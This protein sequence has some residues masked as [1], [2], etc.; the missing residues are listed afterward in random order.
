MRLPVVAVFIILL[1][2]LPAAQSLEK[3]WA[4]TGATLI[5]GTGAAP[6]TDAVIVGRGERLVCVGRAAHCQLP[7]G[8]AIVD[9]TGKWIIPGL[10]DTHIHPG[11][12]NGEG[13]TRAQALRLAFG[14]TTTRDAGT[15][16]VFL[17]NLARRDTARMPTAVEPRLIVSAVVSQEHMEHFREHE[18]GR[19][20][21]R[22]AAFGA[23][24]IK[25]KKAFTPAEYRSI[26]AAAHAAGL[27]VFGHTWGPRGSQLQPALAA[28]IDGLSHMATFSEFGER[29][30]VGR[31]AAPVGF[32]Y[33]LWVK[34]Q[35]NYQDETQLSE[36]VVR[37]VEHG[38]WLEPMLVTEKY[39]TLPYPLPNDVAYLGDVLSLE[40]WIRTS[41][42]VGDTGWVRR[43][44]RRERLAVVYAHMCDIVRRFHARDGVIVTGTDDIA[45]GPG[46]LDEIALLTGCG[47]AP[48]EALRAAT[49]DAAAAI[50]Q[51]DIGTIAAGKLADLVILNG[52]PLSDLANLR[53]VWRVV[54]GGHPHDPAVLLQPPI[55]SYA[56][57]QRR[58]WA[59]RA[60]MGLALG[61]VLLPGLWLGDRR[62]RRRRRQWTASA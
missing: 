54:K 43:Q 38:A 6:L 44:L 61:G 52:D 7:A 22:L 9:A 60:A 25:V 46:L 33:W 62:F 11:W 57:R 28:G 41:L 26:V 20:V 29:A 31:P 37:M 24:A 53:R 59:S 4:I 35:W 5:D 39:F 45:P 12:S 48:M 42:P 17:D 55:A 47:L 10:I 15:P 49:A 1:Q 34:E 56:R 36:A 19:L 3:P 30:D 40:Q 14:T 2:A 18:P 13:A 58:A 23:N 8:T 50:R 51:P 27:P 32:A 21:A 16:G